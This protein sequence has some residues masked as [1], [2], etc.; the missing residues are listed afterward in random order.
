MNI[1]FRTDVANGIDLG[2]G[3]DTQPP[4]SSS[5]ATSMAWKITHHITSNG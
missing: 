2:N 4:L 5:T 3:M 1:V